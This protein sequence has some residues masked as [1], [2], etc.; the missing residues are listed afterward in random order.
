MKRLFDFVFALLAIIILLPVFILLSV[1]ILM[2]SKGGVFYS[3]VRI[4]KNEKPFRLLKFRTMRPGAEIAGQ[5]TV[6]EKDPRITVTGRWLRKYK[7]D[8]LPQLINILKGEMS[9]VGPRP[10]V[11]AY[12]ALYDQ[13]QRQ[14]LTVRPGLTDYA[15]LAYINE[16]EL[17]GRSADPERTYMEEVMPAKL[18]LNLRY[19]QDQCLALDISIIFKTFLAILRKDY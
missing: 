12:V 16:N 8:E 19:L 13:E 15:S 6:G 18:K 11:P 4:G 7:L 1:L 2:T 17:L 10:E 5:L 14:V 9:I 3:Q